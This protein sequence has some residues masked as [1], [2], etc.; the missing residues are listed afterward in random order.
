MLLSGLG[1]QEGAVHGFISL[2]APEKAPR[3]QVG[4]GATAG[5]NQYGTLSGTIGIHNMDRGLGKVGYV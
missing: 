2:K 1:V 4:N 3:R 5:A